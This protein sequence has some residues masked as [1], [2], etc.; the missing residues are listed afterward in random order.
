V[1]LKQASLFK[2]RRENGRRQYLKKLNGLC[3][4]SVVGVVDVDLGRGVN[5]FGV[6]LVASGTSTG[7]GGVLN[8]VS[9]VFNRFKNDGR[10]RPVVEGSE[11][12]SGVSSSAESGAGS[13]EVSGADV[14][15]AVTFADVEAV[16]DGSVG[17][18]R[19][20]K[21]RRL[22]FNGL[23]VELLLLTL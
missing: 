13:S 4:G 17:R 1:L 18:K 9:V 23:A 6:G 2:Q 11:T 20:M 8:G 14:V 16:E 22:R 3:V 12:D 10:V 21:G 7:K 5:G 19:L 15:D